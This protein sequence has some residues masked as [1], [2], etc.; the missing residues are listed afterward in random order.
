[1]LSKLYNKKL[2][3]ETI[4]AATERE[5]DIP[6]IQNVHSNKK[7]S[8][9]GE[10]IFNY[11]PLHTR[12][13]VAIDHSLN[14]ENP[15]IESIKE[16]AM[17]FIKELNKKL[18]NPEKITC[19][20]NC[21]IETLTWSIVHGLSKVNEHKITSFFNIKQTLEIPSEKERESLTNVT[22]C[23]NTLISV[24]HFHLNLK[25]ERNIFENNSKLLNS[26]DIKNKKIICIES[27]EFKEFINK[28][29]S[30]L[31]IT[32][33]KNYLK[34]F[35]II[36]DL[37][38]TSLEKYES[39]KD[40]FAALGSSHSIYDYI[41]HQ[42]EDQIKQLIH[43]YS[44]LQILIDCLKKMKQLPKVHFNMQTGLTVLSNTK[45]HFVKFSKDITAFAENVQRYGRDPGKFGTFYT[46]HAES[47]YLEEVYK[48]Y[49]ELL[50]KNKTENVQLTL[51]LKSNKQT[52]IAKKKSQDQSIASKTEINTSKNSQMTSK[53]SNLNKSISGSFINNQT[54]NNPISKVVATEGKELI[55]N[56]IVL[57]DDKITVK[58]EAYK[59][60]KSEKIS[61]HLIPNIQNIEQFKEDSN[62]SDDEEKELMKELNPLFEIVRQFCEHDRIKKLQKQEEKRKLE[63]EKKRES[64]KKNHPMTN[65]INPISRKLSAE[66]K[67][68]LLNTFSEHPPHL[69]VHINEIRKLAKA[70]GLIIK[71][72]EGSKHNIHVKGSKKLLGEFEHNHGGDKRYYIKS[73]QMENVGD[74]IRAA[75]ENEWIVIEGFTIEIQL[76]ETDHMTT[77]K[78]FIIYQGSRI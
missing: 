43:N 52:R 40:F 72:T 27:K 64:D 55:P 37:N 32:K 3:N 71:D 33:E 76:S 34:I 77:T 73:N 78:K 49:K 53:E 42:F 16:S 67:D 23:F 14:L 48:E 75:I 38:L 12:D 68:L 8:G 45:D 35:R 62:G 4:P 19:D 74:A 6:Q 60:E 9:E 59:E 5:R 31:E 28:T 17:Y 21:S 2:I 26:D 44:Q 65:K 25:R 56:Q 57:D 13:I 69:T 18:K 63:L 10:T 50:E 30:K 61:E 11:L 41:L 22:L 66:Q 15:L 20:K 36:F 54:L 70:C 39:T 29:I 51:D 58:S 1:M 24:A 46:D 7:K 47:K